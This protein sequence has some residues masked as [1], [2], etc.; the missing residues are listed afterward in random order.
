MRRQPG[1]LGRWLGW[2]VGIAALAAVVAIATH[3]SEPRDFARLVERAAPGWIAVALALQAATYLTL[4]QVWRA[5]ARTA[6]RVLPFG[7]AVRIALAKL[8]VDQALPSGGVSGSLMLASALERRGLDRPLIIAM[9]VVELASYYLA[10]AISLAI[11]VV[12]AAAQGHAGAIVVWSAFA[13]V[14]FAVATAIVTITLARTSRVPPNVPGL[15]RAQRWLGVADRQLIRD[16]GLLAR[17]TGWQLAIVALDGLTMWMLLRA[18]GTYAPLAG[19]FASFMIASLARTISIVPGGLGVF[20]AVAVL[21]LH[22]IG[23]PL[24]A[25]LSA[26]LLFRGVS[27]WLPMIPGFV[28]SRR[29][30]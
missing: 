21:T 24:A 29:L 28:A 6:K 27:Y 23:A 10:Y 18:L 4:A 12:I 8:F 25:A 5:V 22:Q 14:V 26:T 16:R 7:P 19:T 13:F 17:A 3:I 1:R 2:L 9:V 15:R 30:R 20:E 11:A